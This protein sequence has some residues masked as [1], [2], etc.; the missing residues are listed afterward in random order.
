MAVKK[1]KKKTT[2]KKAKKKSLKKNKKKDL[3]KVITEIVLSAVVI[4]VLSSAA[5]LMYTGVRVITGVDKIK[6]GGDTYGR[7]GGP[8]PE[9][10]KEYKIP[11]KYKHLFKKYSK[12]ED[13][14]RVGIEE[15]KVL[16]ESGRSVFIDARSKREYM[17]KHI[18]G[19][20][21]MS[22]GYSPEQVK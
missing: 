5:A 21:Y 16:F 14:P 19:S 4:T 10:T 6:T 11:E 2:K 12:K 18:P 17:D 7:A 8:A 15:A 13:I 1:K 20:I 22:S 3:K 9:P